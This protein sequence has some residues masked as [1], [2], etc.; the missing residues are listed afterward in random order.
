MPNGPLRS[1]ES[2]ALASKLFSDLGGHGMPNGE[3]AQACLRIMSEHLQRVREQ[4]MQDAIEACRDAGKSLDANAS[5]LPR[6][7]VYGWNNAVSECVLSLQR[8]SGSPAWAPPSAQTPYL[9]V[10]GDA[11]ALAPSSEVAL[12]VPTVSR[13]DAVEFINKRS[14]VAGESCNSHHIDGVVN[15]IRG[16]IWLM[17]GKDPGFYSLRTLSDALRAMNVPFT[18]VGEGEERM[19]FYGD[20]AQQLADEYRAKAAKDESQEDDD[21]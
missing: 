20:D 13:W 8:L 17:T 6:D 1:V 9:R 11:V 3:N 10:E 4:A 19:V 16:V 7:T 12:R 5:A 18:E 21:G 2:D 15:Q 14:L